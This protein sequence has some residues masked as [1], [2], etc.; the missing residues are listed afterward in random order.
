MLFRK[1]YFEI[2]PLTWILIDLSFN[3][4]NH[5]IQS[6][7]MSLMVKAAHNNGKK[8]NMVRHSI[9]ID[10]LVKQIYALINSKSLDTS[11]DET[12]VDEYSWLYSFLFHLFNYGKNLFKITKFLVYFCKNWICDIARPDFQFFHI[13]VAFESHMLFIWF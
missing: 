13:L 11:L 12:C 2:F 3:C 9:L 7:F 4:Q 10:H 6:F 1:F 5:N 8:C